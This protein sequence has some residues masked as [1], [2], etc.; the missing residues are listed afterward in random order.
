M[1]FASRTFLCSFVPV[2]VLLLGIFCAVERAVVSTVR[3]GLRASLRDHQAS[4]SQMQVKNELQ[5]SRSLRVLSENAV[6]KAG[7]Q[8]MLADP[9]S[10]DVRLTVEDQL[11][12]LSGTAG[13]DFLLV[14]DPNGNPLAGVVRT[15]TGLTPVEVSRFHPPAR[16]FFLTGNETYQITSIPVDQ[17]D[18]NIAVLSLGD[19]FDFAQFNTPAVLLHH[20]KALHSSLS[21]TPLEEMESQLHGCREEAECE[22]RLGGRTYLSLA[23]KTAEFGDGYVLRSLQNLDSAVAPVQSVLRRVFV[24]ACT[25]ALIAALIIAAVSSR[26]IVKPIARVM[27]HLRESEKTGVL[28]K[29]D[30]SIASVQ[31]IREL[32]ESFNRAALAGEEAREKLHRAYVE[33]VGSLASALDARDGYTAGHSRRVSEFSCSVAEALNLGPKDVDELRTG[34]LLHDIG[35]IGIPDSVL[36]KPGRLTDEEFAR[37]QDHPAIG[38]RILEGVNG[39]APY[40]STVGLHHENWDG[41]GYPHGLHG[42]ETPLA[43]RIVHVAD[44]YDAMTSDRPYRK[45]MS[46]EAAVRI[47]QQHRGTQFDPEIVDIFAALVEAGRIRP[48]RESTENHS[49]AMLA[50]AV[51]DVHATAAQTVRTADV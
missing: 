36:Q 16:G 25:G 51:L 29:F 22:V 23:I 1:R 13:F 49:L 47:L 17:G 15:E 6:L 28:P 24:I 48:E 2:A 30:L 38:C 39:L 50:A 33:C 19:R 21:G 40:L 37:I 27:M 9:H 5:N 11:R 10:A 44:A 20:G 18:E 43:A 42:E 7:L 12:E 4:I 14:S 46:S 41:T 8:L 31:E 26:S 3:T 45:G 35:K 32:A 34:A